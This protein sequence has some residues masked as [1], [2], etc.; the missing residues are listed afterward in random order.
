MLLELITEEFWFF[1]FGEIPC[2]ILHMILYNP[3]TFLLISY[4][5]DMKNK[6]GF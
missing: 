1:K 6:N 2:I 5:D 3:L 4:K